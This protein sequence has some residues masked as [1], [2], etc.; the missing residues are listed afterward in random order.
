MIPPQ[1]I[2]FE[3]ILKNCWIVP[4]TA[5]SREAYSRVLLAFNHGAILDFGGL[6][7]TPNGQID[8]VW[9]DIIAQRLKSLVLC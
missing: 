2:L 3:K 5:R 9:K 8:C 1:R 4:A 6:L 7:L